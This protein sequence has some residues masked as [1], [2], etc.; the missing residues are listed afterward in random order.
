[1]SSK[2]KL[3][4]VTKETKTIRFAGFWAVCPLIFFANWSWV[5]ILGDRLR[6]KELK[7]NVEGYGILGVIMV[8]LNIGFGAYFICRNWTDDITAGGK[9][10]TIMGA[11]LIIA[12]DSATTLYVMGLQG[13]FRR[14]HDFHLR[15]AIIA[16]IAC[17][18]VIC[19]MALAEWGQIWYKMKNDPI[20]T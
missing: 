17:K 8:V 5:G 6:K 9:K 15:H 19:L 2:S 20:T 4:L 10:W 13:A 14:E 11:A 1:M 3:V 18:V 16:S 7:K 12:I